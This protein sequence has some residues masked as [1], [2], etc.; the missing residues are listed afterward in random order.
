MEKK[1][2]EI[3]SDCK[4]EGRRVSGFF[5][6]TY[7]FCKTCGGNGKKRKII[8]PNIHNPLALQSLDLDLTSVFVGDKDQSH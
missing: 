1:P 7:G 8:Q 4:G 5:W 6:K 2:Q 3:C